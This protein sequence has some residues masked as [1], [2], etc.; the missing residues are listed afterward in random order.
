MI[1]PIDETGY[2]DELRTLEDVS[3]QRVQDILRELYHERKA[4]PEY[5]YISIYD[6]VKLE[7]ELSQDYKYGLPSL[8]RVVRMINRTTGT[9]MTLIIQPTFS[10]GTLMFL[11][12]AKE[13]AC[14]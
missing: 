1:A 8:G 12:R 6:Q 9:Y 5:L 3:M 11:Y 4:N 2:S 14:G 13:Q 10:A 7:V